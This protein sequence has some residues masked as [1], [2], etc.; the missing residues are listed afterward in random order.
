M[1]REVRSTSWLPSFRRLLAY[2]RPHLRP[3]VLGLVAAIGVSVFY[4]FSVSSVI[5]LLKVVFAD[6]E[7]L[8]DWLHRAETQRR[9]AQR[10]GAIRRRSHRDG[11]G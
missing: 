2:L 5:P 6:H 7:T 9:V 10:G 3:L 11:R 8:A 4:T 1:S